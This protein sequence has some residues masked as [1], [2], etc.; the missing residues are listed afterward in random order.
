VDATRPG[1]DV[2]F[3]GHGWLPTS[4]HRR[5]ALKPGTKLAGPC[6]LEEPGSTILVEPE[7]T[8]DVLA[9]GQLL[10]HTNVAGGAA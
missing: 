10:I 9:D 7:M 1:R 2:H 4:V 3:R 8:V 5:Y 6:I